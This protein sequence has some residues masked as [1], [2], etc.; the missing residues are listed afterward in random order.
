MTATPTYDPA[1]YLSAEDPNVARLLDNV[2]A[3]VP[4]V[5][6]EMVKMQAWNA[7]EDFYIR[8]T[9]RRE[10][11][12]WQMALGVQ[13]LDFNPFD[14]NWL[15]AWVLDVH[16]LYYPKVVMPATIID[17]QPATSVRTGSVLLALKPVAYGTC[18]GILP[19]ELWSQWFETILSGTLARLYLQPAK[20][21]SSPQLAA[22]EM[23]KFRNGINQARD[24][25]DRGFTDGGGRWMYPYFASGKRKN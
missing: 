22:V 21:Y 9:A 13:Q 15:V 20:P 7:I 17:T 10:K 24:I 11:L 3:T 5:T 2:Q 4:S 8:S 25:A 18:C 12:F 1:G 14:E 6:L 16:G 23:R 19:V